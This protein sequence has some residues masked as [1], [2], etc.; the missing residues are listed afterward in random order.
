M[1]I[2]HARIM[3]QL[4]RAGMQVRLWKNSARVVDDSIVGIVTFDWIIR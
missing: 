1:Q 2:G 4:F 3:E